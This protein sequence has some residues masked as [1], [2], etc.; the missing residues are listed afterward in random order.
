MTAKDEKEM[1][2]Q[3]LWG[4]YGIWFS[5]ETQKA[6]TSVLHLG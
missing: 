2:L 5:E 6:L 3:F 4:P 1:Y